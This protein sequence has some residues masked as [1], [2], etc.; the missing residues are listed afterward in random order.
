MNEFAVKSM[1]WCIN[2]DSPNNKKTLTPTYKNIKK[3]EIVVN[4]IR[5][6]QCDHTVHF[7]MISTGSSTL[8]RAAINLFSVLMVN[9]HPITK[10]LFLKTFFRPTHIDTD[11]PANTKTLL[12][13]AVLCFTSFFSSPLPC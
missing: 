1:S 8:G 11:Q 2:F 6:H 9:F 7:L 10:Q 4:P 5:T 3:T 12:A 13:L